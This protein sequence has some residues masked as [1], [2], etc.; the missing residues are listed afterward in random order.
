MTFLGVWVLATKTN[1]A[2]GEVQ[3]DGEAS[4]EVG[5]DH[6]ES[7]VDLEHGPR[8]D[9][10]ITRA[11]S[12][13]VVLRRKASA[14]ALGLSPGQVS[15]SSR[16][17]EVFR[18]AHGASQ[19]ELTSEW[20]HAGDFASSLQRNAT[21]TP[22]ALASHYV[23]L[24]SAQH[25]LIAADWEAVNTGAGAGAGGSLRGRER[26]RESR[27]GSVSARRRTVAFG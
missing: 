12:V 6:A 14:P 8:R 15:I 4:T 3:D 24:T 18:G 21:H 9:P 2:S 13:P 10:S 7:P 20:L 17:S 27:D 22:H 26:G 23:M 11:I 25:L 19:P 1:V 5:P 16:W